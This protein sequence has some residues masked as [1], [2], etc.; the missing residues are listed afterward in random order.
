METLS[1]RPRGGVETVRPTP[2]H[3]ENLAC[4]CGA[5]HLCSQ[6]QALWQELRRWLLAPGTPG[7][8]AAYQAWRD[9]YQTSEVSQ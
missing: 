9:H 3:S 7:F 5:G 6:A 8:Q 2:Y 1:D 4:G